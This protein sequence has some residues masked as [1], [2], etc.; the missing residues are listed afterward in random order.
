VV[1]D[2]LRPLFKNGTSSK[3][4]APPLAKCVDLKAAIAAA[5]SALPVASDRKAERAKDAITRLVARG[6]LACAQEWLWQV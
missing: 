3:P 4:G 2:A 1:L 5:A 6:V